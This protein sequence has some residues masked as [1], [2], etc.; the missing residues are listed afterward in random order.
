M[1]WYIGYV[2]HNPQAIETLRE[3]QRGLWVDWPGRTSRMSLVEVSGAVILYI[4]ACCYDMESYSQAA[5]RANA[6]QCSID[7][8][9]PEFVARVKRDTDELISAIDA[10]NEANGGKLAPDPRDGI[11]LFV[12]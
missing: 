4:D 3:V 11:R 9:K 1:I 6:S 5:H 7:I 12:E 10:Y 8:N 2:F